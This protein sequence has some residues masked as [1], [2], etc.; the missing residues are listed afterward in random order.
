[1]QV[2]TNLVDLLVCSPHVLVARV[3]QE[4][5]SRGAEVGR[6]ELVGLIPAASVAQAAAA[7]GVDAPLDDLGVP[8]A[9][10]LHAA[11]CTLLL[12]RLDADRVLEWHLARQG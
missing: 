4:A 2:S 5:A 12:D 6:G 8:T 9:G 7:A 11:A 10:A 1:V 3:E